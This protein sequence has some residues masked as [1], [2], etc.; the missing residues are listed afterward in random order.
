VVAEIRGVLM[1]QGRTEKQAGAAAEDIVKAAGKDVQ[2]QALHDALNPP[3]HE[4]RKL[5]E[6]FDAAD[7]AGKIQSSIGG[8]DIQKQQLAELKQAK[9]ALARMAEEKFTVRLKK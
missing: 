5:S 1:A 3:Q 4:R 9:L 2:K 8:E 7:L 6:V